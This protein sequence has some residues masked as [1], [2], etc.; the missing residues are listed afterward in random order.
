MV[1]NH[2][3]EQNYSKSK[4]QREEEILSCRG[5]RFNI[6]QKAKLM[7][8]A[9]TTMLWESQVQSS[10]TLCMRFIDWDRHSKFINVAF[11]CLSVGSKNIW[12]F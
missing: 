9:E 10:S 8:P 5:I 3:N 11:S 4:G 1:R 7:Q 12:G 6:Y 2:W